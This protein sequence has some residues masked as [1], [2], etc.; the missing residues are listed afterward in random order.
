MGLLGPKVPAVDAFWPPVKQGKAIRMGQRSPSL[1]FWLAD[2][3]A[4]II[5]PSNKS[6]TSRPSNMLTDLLE[7]FQAL[8]NVSLG[9]V[10]VATLLAA[11][12]M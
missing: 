4:P 10:P 2:N 3:F 9:A 5:R 1:N 8:P 7:R 12:R 11:L 6:S